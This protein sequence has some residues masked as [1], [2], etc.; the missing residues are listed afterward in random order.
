MPLR[1][2]ALERLQIGY[3]HEAFNILSQIIDLSFYFPERFSDLSCH[4]QLDRVLGQIFTRNVRK[5]LECLK[6]I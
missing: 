3:S 2:K 6:L 4:Y 1:S 5:G